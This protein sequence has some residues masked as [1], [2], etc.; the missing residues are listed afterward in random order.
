MR[1]EGWGWVEC[2]TVGDSFALRRYGHEAQAAREPT[3]EEALAIGSMEA[4]RV[5]LS[6]VYDRNEEASREEAHSDED[7]GDGDGG[8]DSCDAYEAQEQRLASAL[9]ALDDS[10][11]I[12]RAALLQW[13]P[14]QLARTGVLLRIDRDGQVLVH[15]GLV[16]PEDAKTPPAS[17]DDAMQSASVHGGPGTRSKRS[18][19]SEALMRDLTAHRTAALQA[20][21]MRNPHVALATLVRRMAETVFDRY[22]WGND[23]VKVHVRATSDHAL[24]EH[25]SD[26]A[27]S[28]AGTLLGQ[29][30]TDWGE[31]IPG[32]P[33]AVFRWLL[34]QDE[35][36]LL[37]L[38]AYC[39]ARSIDVV[40]GRERVRDHSDAIAQALGVDMADW[41]VPSAA[42]YLGRVSKAKALEAVKEATG[43]DAAQAMAGMKKTDVAAHCAVRLEGS[44][45]LPAPLRVIA[46]AT[47]EEDETQA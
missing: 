1:A 18:D 10:L 35:G 5:A 38:L 9:D 13:T 8:C 4:E 15:R 34:A 14:A 46:T 39:T 2:L 23:V 12:A 28:P 26:Y 21:L 44:R 20:A 31:R 27:H 29:A 3:P 40:I 42:N 37:A 36:T 41:W 33:Q 43:V 45:W 32:D 24:A 17:G 6:Q 25:A 11:E 16:R 30:A 7:E 22:G 47:R 19:I